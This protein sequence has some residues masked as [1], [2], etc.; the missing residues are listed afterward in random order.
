MR[1]IG[2][3]ELK[4][5]QLQIL[6]EVVEFCNRHQIKYFLLGGTLLGAVRHQGY[7]PWDDD[8]D[9][10]ML[11]E[12]YERFLELYSKEQ[13]DYYI[14]S[15]EVNKLSSYFFIKVCMKGTLTVDD[16]VSK[17]EPFGVNIDIFPIDRVSVENA[18]SL[19]NKVSFW[20]KF[21]DAKILGAVQ[22]LKNKKKYLP[23][24]LIVK[25]LATFFTYEFIFDRINKLIQQERT[26]HG[27]IK[28]GHILWGY[29]HRELVKSDIFDEM[30]LLPFEG[31]QYSVPKKYDEWLTSVYGNYMELP[32]VEKR[33]ANHNFTAYFLEN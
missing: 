23:I 2:L 29:G 4:R 15:T 30:I 20:R 12:D 10:G 7:I 9:I 8:I 18:L 13:G 28:M 25:I 31:K 21:R 3:D 24:K 22:Y 16:F 5:L 26:K 33:V 19:M 32:P 11:R 27:N 1:Q 6:D 17:N 14:Y